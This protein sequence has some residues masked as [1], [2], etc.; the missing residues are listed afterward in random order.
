[1]ITSIQNEANK[2]VHPRSGQWQWGHPAFSASH[3]SWFM[4]FVA[5]PLARQAIRANGDTQL[6]LPGISVKSTLQINS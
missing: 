2:A 5:E 4:R 6:S 1:M 3:I